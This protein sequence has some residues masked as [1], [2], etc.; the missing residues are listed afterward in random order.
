[1]SA[2]GTKKAVFNPLSKAFRTNPYPFYAELQQSLPQ[3]FGGIWVFTRYADVVALLKDGRFNSASVPQITEKKMAEYSLAGQ[4]PEVTQLGLKAIVFTENPDHARLRKLTN[5]VFNANNVN[6]SVK[7]IIH[8][9]VK[10]L[11][12]HIVDSPSAEIISALAEPLPY[13]M[14]FSWMNLSLDAMPNVIKWTNDV[15]YFLEPSVLNKTRFLESYSSLLD[16]RAF[17]K[18]EIQKRRE[19]PTNDFIGMLLASKTEDDC[20]TEDEIIY[21][22]IFGFVAGTET[23]KALLGDATLLLAQNPDQLQLIHEE[24]VPLLNAA[25][26]LSRRASA[27]Q[28]TRRRCV[29]DVSIAGV[30]VK[31]GE[32]LLAVLAAANHDPTVFPEPEKLLLERSNSDQQVAFG[33]GFHLCLGAHLARLELM[34]YLGEI[35]SRKMTLSFEGEPDWIEHS[36]MLRGLKRFDA[37]VTVGVGV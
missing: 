29:E 20:L 6:A 26:E 12:D 23:T 19:V 28:M 31:K 4:C 37:N 1:M 16:F 22:C 36:F 25:N 8:E 2:T 5:P 24:K 3:Q 30:Q 18:A 14:M 34:A 15:R 27:L 13:H 9:H 35:Q 10:E 11:C 21:A 7:P 17:F 33:Y 32:D